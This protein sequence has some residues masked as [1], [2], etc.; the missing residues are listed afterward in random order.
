[1]KFLDTYAT[2]VRHPEADI[3]EIL[4]EAVVKRPPNVAQVIKEKFEVNRQV[5]IYTPIYE[6][7]CKNLKSSEIKIIPVSGVTGKIL[8]L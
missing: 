4:K 1:M 2:N 5:L 7:R 6:A 3:W 8:S